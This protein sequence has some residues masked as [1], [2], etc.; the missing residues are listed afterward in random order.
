MQS[1]KSA[2]CSFRKLAVR[3]TSG[4]SWLPAARTPAAPC[5]KP[6]ASIPSL[7]RGFPTSSAGS[8]VTR[9]G[10]RANTSRSR[11]DLAAM[12]SA[13][14]SAE[15]HG[16]ARAPSCRPSPDWERNSCRPPTATT[17][18]PPAAWSSIRTAMSRKPTCIRRTASS[19][20]SSSRC[21][22]HCICRRHPRWMNLPAW[23]WRCREKRNPPS[24][25]ATS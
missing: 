4:S 18:P 21:S 5:R 8:P 13:S 11:R 9:N 10:R 25:T 20:A 6:N 23:C 17:P 3:P 16:W 1:W 19:T 24:A 15:P 22:T 2:G 12:T 7:S 14:A